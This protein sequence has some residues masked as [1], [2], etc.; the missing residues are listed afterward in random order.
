MFVFIG[1][2]GG[3]TSSMFCQRIVKASENS[4]LKTSF[5]DFES[6]MRHEKELSAESD[7]IFAYGGIDAIRPQIVY[8]F[9]RLFDVVLIAPQVRFRT[10]AKKEL[11]AD[12][13]IVVKDIDARIF[14]LMDGERALDGLLEELITIDNERGYQSKKKENNKADDKNIDIFIL[15]GDRKEVFFQ[16]F[17]NALRKLGLVLLEESYSLERLYTDP[18]E[19]QYDLRLLY[20]SSSL[21]T[22][23]EFPKFARRIDLVLEKPFLYS[24]FDKKR[25]W[26]E[27]YQIPL[28]SF[29]PVTYSRA[30][31]EL[32]LERLLP[33]IIDAS[34]YTE[35]TKE[36]DTLLSEQTVP[37]QRKHF[38]WF[39]WR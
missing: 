2:A 3:G 12:Y 36:F 37:K 34:L 26:L 11:L 31:G 8:D 30:E 17:T 35:F 24:N 7:I 25:H 5:D 39:S 29:D 28:L 18:S 9:T 10:K 22:E 38:G 4:T 21:I 1:C 32:E 27:D 19:E 33:D 20:G 13:P 15:G 23:E 16:A 14:G 6:V